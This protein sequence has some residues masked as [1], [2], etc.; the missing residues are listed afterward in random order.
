MKRNVIIVDDHK[1]FAQGLS[2]IVESDAQLNVSYIFKDGSELVKYLEI[3]GAE[4][5]DLVITDLSMP[6]MDGCE[7]LK[8]LKTEYLG[9]KVL[10]LSMHN[11]ASHVEKVYNQEASGYILKNAEKSEVLRAINEILS[12]GKYY[13]QEISEVKKVADKHQKEGDHIHLTNREKEVLSL[14]AEEFT[15][16]EIADRLF[17]SKHTVESYRKSLM[18]KLGVKNVVGLTRFAIKVGLVSV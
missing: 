11:D 6:E 18:L 12:G 1:I 17:L 5:I 10:V 14:I 13:S 8:Y 2:K 9:L 7:L 15:T 4:N 3:N 16:Q